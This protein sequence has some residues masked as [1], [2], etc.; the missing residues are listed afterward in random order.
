MTNCNAEGFCR[1][2][3]GGG[4]ASS[5]VNRVVEG[6]DA[7]VLRIVRNECGGKVLAADGRPVVTAG[8]R[9]ATNNFFTCNVL[10]IGVRLVFELTG[11]IGGNIRLVAESRRPRGEGP[12][13]VVT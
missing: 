2:N 6:N 3:F 8:E 1:L 5:S 10:N 13:R 9:R 12:D 7:G 4:G 11:G